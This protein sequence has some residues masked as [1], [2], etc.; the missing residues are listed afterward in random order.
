L[1]SLGRGTLIQIS[2]S[3]RFELEQMLSPDER[4]CEQE[5]LSRL[6]SLAEAREIDSELKLLLAE[7]EGHGK[8][9]VRFL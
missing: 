1:R 7:I 8:V 3:A 2:D 9:F 6:N 4:C 5:Y